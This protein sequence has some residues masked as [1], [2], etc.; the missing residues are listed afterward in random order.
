MTLNGDLSVNSLFTGS[1]ASSLSFTN[2]ISGGGSLTTTGSGVA[3]ISG[4][5]VYSGGTQVS[6][7]TLLVNNMVSGAN[8]GT[9]SG[10][11]TVTNAGSLLGGTGLIAG[12]VT[13]N[14]GAVIQGGTSG[15]PTGTLTVSGALTLNTGGS[16]VQLFLGTGGAH[17]TLATSGATFDANQAFTF[18]L[19]G[20]QPGFYDNII[21][22][23]TA[24]P[25]GES[26]WTIT[27]NGFAGT[28][29]YDGG[30]GPGNIDLTVTSVPESAT[31]WGGRPAGRRAR[32]ES[33]PPTAGL[34]RERSAAARKLRER[35]VLKV[36]S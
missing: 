32:L 14:P 26:S 33:T 1:G 5:N 28:F 15:A 29:A 9:G 24:D 27:N 18:V 36:R 12:A 3:I 6:A 31:V 16:V 20:A 22:G 7:G 11:V 17:S 30:A 34:L 4:A 13:V 10:N 21:T 23:L 19:N 35:P 25:M 2:V 8:S